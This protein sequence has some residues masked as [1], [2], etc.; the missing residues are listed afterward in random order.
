ML[1]W[2]KLLFGA[3]HARRAAAPAARGSWGAESEAAGGTPSSPAPGAAG[4]LAAADAGWEQ[5][6]ERRLDTRPFV[7]WRA[8]G[9]SP[10]CSR[11]DKQGMKGGGSRREVTVRFL[12]VQGLERWFRVLRNYLPKR[13]HH[14]TAVDS[15]F[16]CTALPTQWGRFGRPAETNTNG[17]LVSHRRRAELSALPL[18]GSLCAGPWAPEERDTRKLPSKAYSSAKASGWRQGI[19]ESRKYSNSR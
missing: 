8:A 13:I 14:P 3:P 17:P 1:S 6:S 4:A 5:P 19:G 15:K 7:P 2:H 18:L 11:F 9:T 10:N 16:V 12:A